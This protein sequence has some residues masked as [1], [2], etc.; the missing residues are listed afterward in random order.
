MPRDV[1]VTQP[2]RLI[3]TRACA[4]RGRD[5]PTCHEYARTSSRAASE[6]TRA[7]APWRAFFQLSS[8][9]CRSAPTAVQGTSETTPSRRSTALTRHVLT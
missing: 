9:V 3:N 8:K 4:R 1:S 6:M 2:L 5:L 7:S